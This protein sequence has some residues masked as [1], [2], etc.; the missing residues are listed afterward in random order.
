MNDKPMSYYWK[1]PEEYQRLTSKDLQ[2]EPTVQLL[3]IVLEGMREEMDQAARQVVAYPFSSGYVANAR[4]VEKTL[5][6]D[7]INNITFGH[8]DELAEE[9]RRRCPI[10]VFSE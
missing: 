9:F 6:S 7:F 10:G 2:N 3:E 1:H 4:I 8:G 5:R